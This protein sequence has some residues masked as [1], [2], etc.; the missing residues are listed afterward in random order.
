MNFSSIISQRILGF[1]KK[2]LMYSGKKENKHW[3]CMNF[4]WKGE[5]KEHLGSGKRYS[6]NDIF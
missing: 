2:M 1:I 3:E 5:N 4:L 6:F